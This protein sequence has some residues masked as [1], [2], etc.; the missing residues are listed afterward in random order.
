MPKQPFTAI[1]DQDYFSGS[2]VS[3]YVGDI[4]VDEITSFSYSMS[5]NKNPI[6]GYASQLFDDVAVGQAIVQGNFTINY[7]EQGYLWA[8]LKRYQNLVASKKLIPPVSRETSPATTRTPS[9]NPGEKGHWVSHKTIE[10]FQGES[11]NAAIKSL[12]S[13]GLTKDKVYEN[14]ISLAGHAT[15]DT[16]SPQE[17]A[18]ENLMERFENQVWGDGSTRYGLPS[19]NERNPIAKPYDDF[20]I[21]VVFGNYQND[22]ANHTTQKIEGVRLLSQGKQVVVGGAPIQEEYSFLARTVI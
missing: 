19:K 7:K 1:Y 14:Y 20:D 15:F 8:V 3:I 16:D 12:L 5:Q 10:Q 22:K 11:I 17:R 18:F 21:Y 13:G 9:V 2:Q 6:Y 4:W